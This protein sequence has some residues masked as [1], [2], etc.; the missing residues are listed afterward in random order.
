[1]ATQATQKAETILK[2]LIHSSMLLIG[3]LSLCLLSGLLFV[4]IDPVFGAKYNTNYQDR[5]ATS[6]NYDGDQFNNL[7]PTEIS[8]RSAASPSFLALLKSFLLDAKLKSPRE[9]LPNKAVHNPNLK[10]GE[11]IWFGHSTILLSLSG[12]TLMTDPVFYRASPIPIGGAPFP[13]TNPI[14]PKDLPFVDIVLISH[15]HYDHLDMRSIKAIDSRVKQFLVPLGVKAHLLH[16]G[17]D[18]AKI[19][20][21]DWYESTTVND[22]ELRLAPSRHFS[23]RGLWDRYATLWGAWIIRS[24]TTRYF[25]SG[26]GGYSP[27]F[28]KIGD[29]YGPFDLVMMENGAYDS[30]W[31]QIHMFPE[32]N[33][34]AAKDLRAARIMPIH[35]SKFDLAR[36]HWLDPAQRLSKAA[37]TAKLPVLFPVIGEVFSFNETQEKPWWQSMR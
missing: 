27:E 22:V 24:P 21:F 30:D 34:Q 12:I 35:W 17:I 3:F 11:L 28:K 20:E 23:G 16:W 15:D 6:K 33:V 9:P 13:M 18:E 10:D 19:T 31:A 14:K 37:A 36:H 7:I 29:Q 26:D 32:E 2:V 8:T 25:F 1:M 4:S 5:Y